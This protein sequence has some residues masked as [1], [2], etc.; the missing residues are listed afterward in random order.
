MLADVLQKADSREHIPTLE[1]RSVGTS[2]AIYSMNIPR[3]VIN[4]VLV[5]LLSETLQSV[6]VYSKFMVLGTRSHSRPYVRV[7]L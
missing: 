7:V 5:S 2:H 4:S 3:T 6:V 1:R